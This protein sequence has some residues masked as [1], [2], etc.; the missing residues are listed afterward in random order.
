[1]EKQLKTM[2]YV[3]VELFNRIL[4]VEEKAMRDHGIT[5]SMN[6]IHVLEAINNC[7]T[8]TMSDIAQK[9]LITPGTLTVSTKK[10]ENKGYICKVR[11]EKDKRVI[12]IGLT[13]KA[14]PI[15]TIHDTFHKEMIEAFSGNLKKE[16]LE[17]LSRALEQITDFFEHNNEEG[18][19]E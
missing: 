10:L 14:F 12:R 16:E 6:E 5:L 8:K 18:C 15:L 7:Q 13:E 9:L 4:F 11:D 3:V 2:N 1:M 17:I 19:N